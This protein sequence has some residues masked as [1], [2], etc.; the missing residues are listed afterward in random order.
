MVVPRPSNTTVKSNTFHASCT[1]P[2]P[3]SPLHR[4]AHAHADMAPHT[5]SVLCAVACARPRRARTLKYHL[6]PRP[7]ILIIA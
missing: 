2:P 7:M 4:I 6:G 3:L 5:A 1:P